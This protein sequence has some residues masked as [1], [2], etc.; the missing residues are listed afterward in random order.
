[1]ITNYYYNEQLK[2]YLIQFMAIFVGMDVQTGKAKDGEV[3]TIKVP[4]QYGSKDRVAAAILGQNVQ[5]QPLRLPIMSANLRSIKLSKERLKG[6]GQVRKTPYV[7]RGGL[8]PDDVRV[9][10]QLMP[11][12]YDLNVELS[13]YTSNLDQHF[14]ILE[15]IF[16]L[17]DPTLTIQ[18]SDG[19]FD[20]AKLTTV[21]LTDVNYEERYPA[22]T[23]RRT[24]TSTI[25]FNVPI[26]VSVPLTVKDDAIKQIMIRVG[27]IGTGTDDISDEILAAL[28]AGGFSY[29]T[30]IDAETELN[31]IGIS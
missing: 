20:W 11:V 19:S 26:Y 22:G 25:Q 5:N 18:T 14:Q 12:P 10:K 21:E 9:V 17:F 15:Q 16:I 27:A 4:I 6:V 8:V 31:N 28:D 23:E 13:V 1:M 2:K 30:V 24:T 3:K 7:P 29:E